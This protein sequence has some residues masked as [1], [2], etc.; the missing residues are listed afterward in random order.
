MCHT[1]EHFLTSRILLTYGG[2]SHNEINT[3]TWL[4]DINLR[5]VKKLE[6][7]ASLNNT[8]FVMFSD[9]G[10]RYGASRLNIGAAVKERLPFMVIV[11]PKWFRVKYP[12]LQHSLEENAFRLTTPFDVHATMIYVISMAE[13]G[14]R[15]NRT[16][17]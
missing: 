7:Q 5:A 2:T 13:G 1:P 12:D 8:I 16:V 15:G 9:H 3:P 14:N 11:T 17:H 4:D 6:K 10:I